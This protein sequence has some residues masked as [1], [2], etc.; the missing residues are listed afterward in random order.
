LPPPRDSSLQVKGTVL[1]MP[2]GSDKVTTA[3]QQTVSS[4]KA[5]TDADI[6]TL[7]KSSLKVSKKK[8]KPAAKKEE[9]AAA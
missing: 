7:L 2:N 4:E 5:V 8:K 3:P 9:E 1:L 6:L